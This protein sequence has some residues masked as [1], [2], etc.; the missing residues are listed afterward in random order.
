MV[1]SSMTNNT[2]SP[3]CCKTNDCEGW[4]WKYKA[5]TEVVEFLTEAGRV[6]EKIWNVSVERKVSKREGIQLV[7]IPWD[8]RNGQK[9]IVDPR[10]KST[11][12][13]E[14]DLKNRVF[15]MSMLS[16]IVL[17]YKQRAAISTLNQF[18]PQL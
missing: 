8:A 3:L 15:L 11:C 7:W 1:E 4:F 10:R 6:E 17:S 9:D 2:N 12:V 18:P 5:L 14:E 16:K 13:V